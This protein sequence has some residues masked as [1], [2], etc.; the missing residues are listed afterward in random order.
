MKRLLFLALIAVVLVGCSG[1]KQEPAPQSKSLSDEESTG[2]EVYTMTLVR[3]L[4]QPLLG[5]GTVARGKLVPESLVLEKGDTIKIENNDLNYETIQ[6]IQVKKDYKQSKFR[7]LLRK[8]LTKGESVEYTFEEEGSYK[9]KCLFS[10]CV[11]SVGVGA[12]A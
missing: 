7:T 1:S 2:P 11:S 8:E 6:I 3:E 5:S 12:A 4:S 10:G 9:V